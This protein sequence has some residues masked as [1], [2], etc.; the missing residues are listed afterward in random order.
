MVTGGFYVNRLSDVDNTDDTDE[1]FDKGLKLMFA[2]GFITTLFWVS[3]VQHMKI[4]VS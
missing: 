4:F 2:G 1:D 3:Y